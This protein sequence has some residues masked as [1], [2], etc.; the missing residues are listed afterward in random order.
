MIIAANTRGTPVAPT[1][2]P[3]VRS[4]LAT[5]RSL[6]AGVIEY[7]RT[8]ALSKIAG[9]YRIGSVDDSMVAAMTRAANDRRAY[10]LARI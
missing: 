6:R 2:M 7:R 9:L 10:D 1:V 3:T 4:G 5:I 8:V